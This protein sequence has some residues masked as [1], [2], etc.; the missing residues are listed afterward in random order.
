MDRSCGIAPTN[1]RCIFWK[2]C[3]TFMYMSSKEGFHSVK[4]GIWIIDVYMYGINCDHICVGN[5]IGSAKFKVWNG[6]N[7]ER[8]KLTY[9]RGCDIS[10][11]A[12]HRQKVA[13]RSALSE[14]VCSWLWYVAMSWNSIKIA[15][16]NSVTFYAL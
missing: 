1:A 12:D 10:D 16:G 14:S 5:R 3:V 8:R 13:A 15:Y 4:I 11:S 6:E 9:Q 2:Y 7:P